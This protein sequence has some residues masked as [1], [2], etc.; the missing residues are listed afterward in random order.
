MM[1]DILDD[2]PSAVPVLSSDI[3]AVVEAFITLLGERGGW[4]TGRSIDL[5]GSRWTPSAVKDDES[6]VLYAFLGEDI[7]KFIERRLREA[8]TRGISVVVAVP[9]HSVFR[10]EIVEL[11]A[12]LD[13]DIA[14]VRSDWRSTSLAVDEPRHFLAALA[15]IEV[16]LPV[17]ARK[18]VAE[19]VWPRLREGSNF[20]KGRR[21]ESL[22]AFVFSQVSD[23]KVV[24]RNYR[25]E[26]DEIDIVL[27]I[28]G[29]SVYSWHDQGAPFVFVEAKNH[30]AKADQP[31][32]NLLLSKLMTRR[33]SAQMGILVSVGG[34]TEDARKAELRMSGMG[35]CIVMID[36]TAL[37]SLLR[38]DDLDG[39][40][41]ELVRRALLR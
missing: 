17:A 16:P 8:R 32:V 29:Q 36:G 33:R 13:A 7:P 28:N 39:K 38:S 40:L 11:L 21:L 6:A 22:L 31:M 2:G 18:S 14:M 27:Q 19:A 37:Q 3:D 1:E 20:E 35:V 25:S 23:L 4:V 30:A 12:E 9:T 10:V 26:T 15:D 24:E 41:E 34:F 5:G